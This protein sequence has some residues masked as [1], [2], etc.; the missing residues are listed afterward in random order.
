[1]FNVHNAYAV[2]IFDGIPFKNICIFM[3][4][5][6]YL[7]LYFKRKRILN[8]IKHRKKHIADDYLHVKMCFIDQRNAAQL[9]LQLQQ[10]NINSYSHFYMELEHILRLSMHNI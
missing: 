9:L 2:S 8:S 1:M 5:Y 7:C 4:I 3:Y 6:L 10:S